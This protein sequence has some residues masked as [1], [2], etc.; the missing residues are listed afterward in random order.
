MRL[1]FVADGRSPIALNWIQH[2]VQ[3]GY[4]VHLASTFPCQPELK[5]ASLH[6][7]P[8]AFS[9]AAGETAAR[10]GMIRTFTTPRLRTAL[11]QWLGPLTLARAGRRL[12]GLIHAL[13]PD[14]V[15]AMRIPYEGMIAALALAPDV[16]IRPSPTF[17]L[18][19]SSLATRSSLYP[20]PPLYPTPIPL[21]ISVWGNDFTLHA[22][23][24]P[25]MARYTRLALRH[26]NALH[27]DCHRDLRLAYEWGFVQGKPT[28]TVPGNGGIDLEIFYPPA[29]A[30]YPPS[31]SPTSEVF[32]VINP[33]GFRAYVRNDTFFKAIPRVLEKYPQTR[34]V[35]PAMAGDPHI[36]VYQN[37][38]HALNIGDSVEFLPHLPRAQMAELF[39]QADVAVSPSE[40]DG[41]PNTLLE[42][43]ACGCLPIAGDIEAI[44]E[45]II[46]GENGLL[47]DPA[48]A[49][50]L[51]QAIVRGLEDV[52][53]RKRAAKENARL[54]AD[55]AEYR[56]TME[57]VE[58]FYTTLRPLLLS[59]STLPDQT[60]P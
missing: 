4:E 10:G 36:T 29:M 12:R 2:F 45:W 34:F 5:L 32:T 19:Q 42:A 7:V 23:S 20:T 57:R 35:C 51:A 26:A 50:A 8:V 1:L 41:T 31:P 59:Q 18:V 46:P 58:Q 56:K 53:L 25:L 22:R 52:K 54:I 44:R 48:D 13:Q 28:I 60:R 33:R 15:H 27:T 38:L 14:L 9:S 37:R 43:M 16:L 39:R 47:F 21:L 6:I 55:W 11:R 17:P 24:T 30:V 3:T 40:H 49:D